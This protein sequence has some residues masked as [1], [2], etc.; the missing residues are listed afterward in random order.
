VEALGNCPVCPPPALN[1][2]LKLRHECQYHNRK[3]KRQ[4]SDKIPL[5]CKHDEVVIPVQER[6]Y[7]NAIARNAKTKVRTLYR[8]LK[9]G[10][11]A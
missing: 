4:R 1:P 5:V 9:S 6:S 2:T 11:G 3:V 7:S 8:R 10:N